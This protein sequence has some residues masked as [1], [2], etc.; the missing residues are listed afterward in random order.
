MKEKQE[1]AKKK[2]EENSRRWGET[3][4]KFE[5]RQQKGDNLKIIKKKDLIIIRENKD[6]YFINRFNIFIQNFIFPL[7]IPLRKNFQKLL[8]REVLLSTQIMQLIIIY[9][10]NGSKFN[11]L[12]I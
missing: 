9:I 3:R 1:E 7:L 11:F 2:I 6:D 12:K 4:I 10:D 5:E 8:N